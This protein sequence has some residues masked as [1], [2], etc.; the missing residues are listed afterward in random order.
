[1]VEENEN[2]PAPESTAPPTRLE[3][4]VRR[5]RSSSDLPAFAHDIQELL[6][7]TRDEVASVRRLTGV[8]LKNLSLTTKLIRT[9]NSVTFNRSGREILSVAHAVTLLG[10]DA[11]R[12]LA[13]GLLFFEKFDRHARDV[14]EL[15]LV[16]LLT[17]NA[18]RELAVRARYPHPEEAYLAGML[19][20]LGELLAA[21]YLPG[22][23]RQVLALMKQ[24][25]LRPREAAAEALG[26]TFDELGRAVIGEWR[27]PAKTASGM[28]P[29]E[30]LSG[31]S[32]HAD[33]TTLEIIASV[34]RALT[35]AVYREE[36][37]EGRK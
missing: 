28:T 35:H 12:T 6:T 34:S 1:M 13:S 27:L 23:Y 4:A 7:V 22:E 33:E 26:F 14:K 19:S 24:R 29:V 5:I 10:W 32:A 36:P 37:D 16:S 11:V 18:A 15:T 25:G 21:C 31:R 20:G 8:I 2:G 9:V 17:A 30:R 3:L